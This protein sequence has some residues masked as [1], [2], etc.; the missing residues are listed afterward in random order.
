MGSDIIVEWIDV[1]GIESEINLPLLWR[2]CEDLP[3]GMILARVY[4][5]LIKND[6]WEYSA[7]AITL[8]A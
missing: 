3:R 6:P 5:S 1:T 7:K 8:L 4:D 2:R